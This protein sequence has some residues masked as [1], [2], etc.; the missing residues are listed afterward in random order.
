MADVF[1]SYAREDA[2]AA[3]KLA[4]FLTSNGLD[5]W[6]DRRLRAADD[7]DKVID[8]E[9]AGRNADSADATRAS[10][11]T[12][13]SA[14]RRTIVF[15]PG[16]ASSFLADLKAVQPKSGAT[17]SDRR[18]CVFLFHLAAQGL[19]YG[20]NTDRHSSRPLQERHAQLA[21]EAES[22]IDLRTA[23]WRRP[24]VD[25]PPTWRPPDP[26]AP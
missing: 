6:W 20:R 9:L 2:G 22:G 5:V 24:A 25:P 4:R 1:L 14:A 17:F 23:H 19:T 16:M 11:G 21:Y 13:E 12:R 7:I 18:R 10:A 15:D 3:E 8:R 26:K